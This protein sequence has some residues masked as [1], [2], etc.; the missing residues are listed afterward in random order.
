MFITLQLYIKTDVFIFTQLNIFKQQYEGTNVCSNE[1]LNC[2]AKFH[3]PII[4]NTIYVYA[5]QTTAYVL[6]FCALI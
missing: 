6:H 4:H 2:A 3:I 5:V 1:P